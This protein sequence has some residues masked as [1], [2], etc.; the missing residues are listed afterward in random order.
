MLMKKTLICLFIFSLMFS[1]VYS[2]DYEEGE[3]KEYVSRGGIAEVP[4]SKRPKAYDKKKAQEAAEKDENPEVDEK[5]R[6]TIMF[7]TSSEVSDLLSKLIKDDD[8]RYTE[9]IYDLFQETQNSTV[10]QKV[11][12]YF[13]K[14]EDP[15]LED[16]AVELLN[17]PY[18]EKSEVVQA[19][20]EYIGAVKTKA[21]IPAVITL[22]ESENEVYFNWAVLCL[23]EIGEAD[24]AMFLA[25]YLERDDIS[26]PQR[27]T[28]MRVCG[29]MHAVETYDLLVDILENE[30]ENA[31]VR[32]YAAEA[33]G[34]M[35]KP[36]A[37]K[38]LV[39]NFGATD[40]N[41]RQYVVKGIKNFPESKDA[42]RIILQGIKDDH[43]KVRQEAIKAVKE[44]KMTSA[45]QTLIYR[46]K[47]DSEKV[48]K[49]ECYNT[50]G[51]LNTSDGNKFLISQITDEKSGDTVKAKCV[52]VL[53][54]NGTAGEKEILAL[55]EE[56]LKDDRRKSLRTAIGK[57]LA[58]YNRP[59]F[60]GICGMYLESKDTTTVSL[61]LDMYKMGKYSSAES[62]VRAIALD[63][64]ANVG[65]KK[66]A[67]KMLG[68]E[69]TTETADSSKSAK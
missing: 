68:I 35:K 69:E 3:K 45:V 57:E 41:L 64:K 38:V 11:L 14:C 1:S 62:K 53:L 43:W 55:A 34:L 2:S 60:A 48:I 4:S 32:M 63:K 18:D 67:M 56:T 44:M 15:C 5:N 17:D 65:N 30:D 23:G 8:P 12:N 52:E 42:Q 58:K 31:F 37:I 39:R 24:E 46:A 28:I 13:G 51:E 27:Q 7:G 6:N 66:R 49:D 29:K 21:A 26:I 59:G 10:K 22:I 36:E 61:G 33:L 16:F 19:A 50:L 20:F 47:N 25:E 9:E 40:P 54:K